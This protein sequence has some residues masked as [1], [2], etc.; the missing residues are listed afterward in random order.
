MNIGLTMEKSK[1]GFIIVNETIERL[2]SGK[3]ILEQLVLELCPKVRDYS[4]NRI[5]TNRELDNDICNLH[6]SELT[7]ERFLWVLGL[8]CLE[9]TLEILHAKAEAGHCKTHGKGCR[10]GKEFHKSL[11]K[12]CIDTFEEV[13]RKYSINRS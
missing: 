6:Y 8:T 2:A 3:Y 5:G 12:Y 4:K 10:E 9:W 11:Y 13:I 1:D 7:N